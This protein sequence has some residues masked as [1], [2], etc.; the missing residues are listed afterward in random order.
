MSRSKLSSEEIRH[1]LINE[2]ASLDDPIDVSTLR[3]VGTGDVWKAVIV[4]RGA[5]VDEAQ[6]AALYEARRHLASC[7]DLDPG[8][9]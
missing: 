5:R 8:A 2:L 6:L 4:T 3:I 9:A 7:Y 1:R